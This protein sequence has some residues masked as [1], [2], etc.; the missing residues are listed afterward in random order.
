MNDMDDR[1][2]IGEV[3]RDRRKAL[4]L[5][6]KDLV[7]EKLSPT[8]ISY[9]ET[10]KKKASKETIAYLCQKIDLD[11]K[12][13]PQYFEENEKKRSSQLAELKLRLKSIENDI[14]CVGARY[15][16]AQLKTIDTDNNAYLEALVAYLMGKCYSKKKNWIRALEHY[17]R[18]IK[19][20]DEH[21]DIH[22]SNMKAASLYGIARVYYRQNELEN[23]L[24]NVKLG[25]KSFVENGEKKYYKYHL[26]ISQAIYSDKMGNLAE[27][28]KTLEKMW[29][30]LAEID[31]ETKLNMYG[32]QAILYNKYKM[33]EEAITCID[34]AIDI[35]RQEENFDHCFELW[36]TLGVSYKSLGSPGF[37]KTCLETAFRFQNK[38]RNKFLLPAYNYAELGK[39]HLNEGD[40]ELA[41]KY[42]KDAVTLSKK[43]NDSLRQIEAQSALGDCYLHQNKFQKA[44]TQYEEAEQVAK[45]HSFLPQER[46]IVLKLAQCFEKRDMVKYNK[47]SA[48]LFQIS[49]KLLNR[50][51]NAMHS[52]ISQNLLTE[53]NSMPDPPND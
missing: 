26:M 17:Q 19:I 10:G 36:T 28:M 12:K 41:E 31:N 2:L 48:R 5:R 33:Y 9:I 15:A 29:S 4:G 43:A 20:F 3:I 13:L 37:A 1:K 24:Y 11:L 39:L 40:I 8:I 14:D 30:H 27:A 35:A 51:D 22:F 46:D 7:D 23:A 32:L 16:L 18:S 38:L 6:Q 34:T 21:P 53:R 52:T 44:V 42:L 45:N 47:Y 49:V 25:L 50:G